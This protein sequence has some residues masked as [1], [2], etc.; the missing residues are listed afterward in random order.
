MPNTNHIIDVGARVGI[1]RGRVGSA[2]IHV[3]SARL[4]RY[5]HV[6]IGKAKCSH[7]G[8]NASPQG[9]QLRVVLEY[10]YIGVKCI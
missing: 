9:K 1:V 4:F 8:P 7:W 10:I 2:M 6:G 5:H 3:G